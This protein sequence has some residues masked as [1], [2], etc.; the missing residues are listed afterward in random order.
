[1]KLAKTRLKLELEIPCL[2]SFHYFEFSKDF[3]FEGE[4]HDCWELVYVDSGE[5]AVTAG[6]EGY[7]L[8]QGDII[9][10]K[11]NEFH[12]L[13]TNKRI[14][15]NVV[16]IAFECRS[17]SMDFFKSKMFNLGNFERNLL[18]SVVKY[19]F[20][21]FEPP[22][23]DPRSNRLIRKKEIPLGAEQLIRTNLE[24]LLLSIFS[25]EYKDV[26]KTR[27][28]TMAREQDDYEL[29][30]RSI[31]YMREELN[32]ELNLERMCARLHISKSFL[33]R[34]F[35]KQ[36]GQSVMAYYKHLKIEKAK[37]LIRERRYNFTEISD[38]L[39]YP[40]IHSFSRHFKH[41]TDMTPSAYSRSIQ[42]RL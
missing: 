5:L 38:I 3:L 17:P 19:G 42:A 36:T 25:Q 7:V 15:P 34:R 16:V 32:R 30:E 24:M 28:S 8:K 9:F 1:M 20:L 11:P 10:H 18:A 13:R 2:Y 12:S 21:A 27:L 39:G 31:V 26:S 6:Q 14:A 35:K 33:A 23:N 29:A 37:T 40:S 22:L 41:A 4:Q